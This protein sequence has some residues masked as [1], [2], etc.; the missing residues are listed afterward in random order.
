MRFACSDLITHIHREGLILF[1]VNPKSYF[2]IYFICEKWTKKGKQLQ[3]KILY[4]IRIFWFPHR[5]MSQIHPNT[6]LSRIGTI[7]NCR[8]IYIYTRVF[9]SI[10]FTTYI[11]ASC[12]LVESS[13]AYSTQTKI[14][15]R[16]KTILSRVRNKFQLHC[17][18]FYLSYN[19]N[20]MNIIL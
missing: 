20:V 10:Y 19:N 11:F 14:F 7:I 18:L 12:R 8:C 1:M 17:L 16:I 3:N 4:N 5:K 15:P 9:P 6:I 2:I 13:H